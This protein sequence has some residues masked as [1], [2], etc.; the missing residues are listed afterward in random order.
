MFACNQV[1]WTYN[2]NQHYLDC[3][4]GVLPPPEVK[5]LEAE[6]D[7]ILGAIAELPISDNHKRKHTNT[8]S[9]AARKK[10]R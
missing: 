10:Q 6:Q 1:H 3:H 4:P 7:C 8:A 9:K 5:P 2:F